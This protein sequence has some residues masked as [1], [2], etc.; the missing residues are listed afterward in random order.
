MAEALE[1]FSK[2]CIAEASIFPRLD[3]L[4]DVKAAVEVLADECYAAPE[5]FSLRPNDIVFDGGALGRSPEMLSTAY[6]APHLLE[7]V[8]SCT[9]FRQPGNVLLR[10]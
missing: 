9:S 5:P 4:S 7:F 8:L 2:Q 10:Y 1:G 6:R 3:N